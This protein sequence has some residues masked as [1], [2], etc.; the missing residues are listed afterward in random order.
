MEKLN[1]QREL[2]QPLVE[3]KTTRSQ[4]KNLK[5]RSVKLFKKN[6]IVEKS[7]GNSSQAHIF[8]GREPILGIRVVVKQY[9]GIKKNSILAEI[10]T[11][12]L[13]EQLRQ[14]Q[15]G[16]ELKKQVGQG[17]ELQALP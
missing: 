12:T 7:S 10:K 11:F 1:L 15:A 2:K 17:S 14:E 5:E 13:L 16:S 8:F 3:N 4:K 6:I 9:I